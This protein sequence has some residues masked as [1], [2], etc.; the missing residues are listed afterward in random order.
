MKTPWGLPLE[1]NSPD[2]ET[3]TLRKG[4]STPHYE[5][6]GLGSWT[7]AVQSQL[8][9]LVVGLP[10]VCYLIPLSLFPHL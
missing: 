8:L 4:S 5:L 9:H 1:A 6:C 3:N 2:K 10:C 7:C